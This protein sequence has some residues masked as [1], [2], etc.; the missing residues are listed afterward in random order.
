MVINRRPIYGGRSFN[1]S[2]FPCLPSIDQPAKASV[3]TP[4]TCPQAAAR[5][6]CAVARIEVHPAAP[7]AP[8]GLLR[9]RSAGFF[10]TFYLWGVVMHLVALPS[11]LLPAGAAFRC[12]EIWVAGILWLMR[13]IGGTQVEIRGRMPSADRPVIVA[14]KHQSAWD[15]L[16]FAVLLDRPAMVMKTE[17]LWIPVYGWMSRKMRMIAVDRAAGTGAM[18]ALIARARDAVANGR[19]PVIFPEGTRVHPDAPRVAFQPGIAALYKQLAVPVVPVALNSG[20]FWS[21]GSLILHP[22][23]IV[24][25]FLEPIDPGLERANFMT[26]LETRIERASERLLAEARAERD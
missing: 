3:S 17:L 24:L 14:A 23:T 13:V 25:E 12:T 6:V 19:S 8:S 1:P 4:A 7:P 5:P 15:T 9:L 26:T 20:L 2:G 18:R 21:R 11:L 10:S 22:G 16:I